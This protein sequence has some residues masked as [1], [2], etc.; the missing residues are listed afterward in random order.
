MDDTILL[1]LQQVFD[2]GKITIVNDSHKHAG[3]AGDNGTGQSHYTVCVVSNAFH[4]KS[5]VQSQRMVNDALRHLMG[6]GGIHALSIQ[7][8]T[9]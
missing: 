9:P 4:G 6:D 8:K 1:C 3:H 2:D 5:R 7:T